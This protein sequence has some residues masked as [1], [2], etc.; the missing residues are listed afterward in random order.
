MYA[1]FNGKTRVVKI[2]IDAGADVNARDRTGSTT[3]MFAASGPFPDTVALLLDRGAQINAIDGNEHFT[4]LMWAAAE[5]Q[6]EVV[7]LLLKRGADAT[8]QDV[9]GDTAESFAAQKGHTAI[10]KII[11]AA[12]Q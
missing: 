2:L 9:D 4:P 3:L 6:A 11:Q 12:A 7:A 8:L 1:A 10:I 5:G